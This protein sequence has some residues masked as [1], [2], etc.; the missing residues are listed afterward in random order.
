[1]F[2]GKP[3]IGIVGGIGSGKSV[4]ARMFAELGGVLIDSD[5][6]VHQVYEREDVRRTLKL[7]WGDGVFHADGSVDR[8]AIAARVFND[9][10][11]LRRLE[12]L[13]HPLVNAERDRRMEQAAHDPKVTAFIWD[14]PLLLETGGQTRCDAVVFV[15]VPLDIRQKRTALRGWDAAELARRENLQMPLDKKRLL[16]QYVVDNATDA[17]SAGLLVRNLFAKIQASS[18]CSSVFRSANGDPA[19]GE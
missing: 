18:S 8:R 4:I 13:V 10:A 15:D 19:S 17:D 7:W 16:S 5:A 1:M 9:S 14:T 6:L 3:I 12:A 2:H 11:E